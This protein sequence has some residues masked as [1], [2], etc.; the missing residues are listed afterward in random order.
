VALVQEAKNPGTPPVGWSTNPNASDNDR[1]ERWRISVPRFYRDA[2][3]NLEETRRWF[4]SAVATT[5]ALKA[6]P[7]SAMA[8][9]EAADGELAS[10]HPGQFAVTD[11]EADNDRVVTMISLYG[12]WD[13][14]LDSGDKYTEATLHRAVSDLTPIFQERRA[15]YVLIA[16]DLN[17]YSYSDGSAWGER[18]M[19]VLARLK[20]YG[21][22]LCGPFRP[23]SD[24]RLDR[25]PCPD[26]E[27]RHVNTFLYKSDP[28]NLPHQ[29]DFFL[30]S[31]KLRDHLVRSW[32][33]PD[34][35][36]FDHSDHRAI[37]VTF[38]L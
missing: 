24:P 2:D 5:G 16:G 34:P 26:T 3:G 35:R 38:D 15:D 17:L 20:T 10:S 36:W 8:L 27:C 11:V 1:D 25:C 9:H 22:E 33:D 30:A 23:E 28:K 4:A 37:F 19:T 12:I 7:R 31:E 13:T 21:I 6:R 32:A 14:M 18:W 29:L